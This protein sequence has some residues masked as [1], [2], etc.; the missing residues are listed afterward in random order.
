MHPDVKTARRLQ[1]FDSRLDA[2]NEEVAALPKQI[3]EIERTLESHQKHLDIEKMTLAGNQKARRDFEGQI[4]TH[5]Q[6]KSHLKNQMMEARTNEQYW[7]FQKEIQYLENEVGAA[8]DSILELMEQAEPLDAKVKQAEA[9]LAQE[10]KAVE[11][12]KERAQLKTDE[13]KREIARLSAEREEARKEMSAP[14]YRTYENLRKRPK[15]IAVAECAGG[16]CSACHM[17]IRPQFLQDLR[18]GDHVMFCE[19]CGRILYLETAVDMDEYSSSE[20]PT[21]P[22]AVIRRISG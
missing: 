20:T 6:K 15:G 16:Q 10:R 19:N 14:I 18:R 2:L 13:D 22:M 11:A 8:E 1:E 17:M 5:E 4:Q 9:A 7:A 12:E 3:A 21:A